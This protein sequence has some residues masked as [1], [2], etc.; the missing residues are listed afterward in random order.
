MEKTVSF[1][2]DAQLKALKC[3]DGIRFVEAR[4]TTT[5]GLSVRVTKD[6]TK[7]LFA[8]TVRWKAEERAAWALSQHAPECGTPRGAEAQDGAVRR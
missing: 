5:P 1:S 7:T 3:P 2:N 8:R 4:D 6:G